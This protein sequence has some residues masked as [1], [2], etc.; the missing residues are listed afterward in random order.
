MT[1]SAARA[2]RSI[3]GGR[4]T[5]LAEAERLAVEWDELASRCHPGPFALAAMALPW[6]AEMGKGELRIAT[7]RAASGELVGLAACHA[8][9]VAGV[10]LVR[11]LGHGVGAVASTLVAP[12]KANVA[13]VLLDAL[14][15]GPRTVVHFADVR[16]DDPLVVHARRA[17]A[18]SGV[19]LRATLHDACPQIGLEGVA[20]SA[21][22]LARPDHRSLRKALARVDRDL[23]GRT[24]D[25]EVASTPAEV[26]AALGAVGELFDAAEAAHPRA[27]FGRGPLGDFFGRATDGLAAQGRVT[28]LT[29]VVDG[30]PAAFDVYVTHGDV[31]AAVLGRYDPRRADL[32]PGHLLLRAGVDRAIA[33]GATTIDLQLGADRYK[34]AWSTGSVDTFEV[35]IG[36]PGGLGAA[37]AAV[38]AME[39]AHRLR[40]RILDRV[41]R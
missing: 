29:L 41:A 35:L 13:G 3:V 28:V 37:A 31:A 1:R 39:G 23:A 40:G 34:T 11:P 17:R 6:W 27:H 20:S 4:V 15:G 5:T 10:E 12:V 22:L 7:A 16:L 36:R 14:L 9:R 2:A 24:V 21:E 18:E 38:R 26:V 33:S 30:S 25:V 32:S 19:E 8:R